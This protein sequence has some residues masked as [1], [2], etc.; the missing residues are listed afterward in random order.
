MPI[1]GLL[2][3]ENFNIVI[4]D[5]PGDDVL[6]E[7][8][9][10]LNCSYVE[11]IACDGFDMWIDDEGRIGEDRV[12]NTLASIAASRPIFGHAWLVGQDGGSMKS[13]SMNQIR[14]AANGGMVLG[15]SFS[16]PEVREARLEGNWWLDGKDLVTA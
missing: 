13:L 1:T 12:I 11:V 15:P 10:L 8:Y 3:D 4:V 14:E 16:L 6:R 5:L 9:E 7:M 2:M